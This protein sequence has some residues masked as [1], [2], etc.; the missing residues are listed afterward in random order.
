MPRKLLETIAKGMILIGDGAMGTQLQLV[1]LEPGGCGEGWNVD[2]PERV[3]GIQQ[4]YVDAGSQCLI[5]N[6]FG[7]SRITLRRHKQDGRAYEINRAASR[8]ARD[9]LGPDGF[10]LG[11]IGPFGGFLE[12]LGEYSRNE[13]VDV[14]TEQA[15]GLLDGGADAIIVETMTAL[16]EIEAAVVAARSVHS[17]CTLIGSLAYDRTV[18]DTYR[19]MMGIG[20][21]ES[22]AKL[23]EMGIDV[24]ACN[25]GTGID[26]TDYVRIVTEYRNCSDL[27]IM[28]QPNAGQPALMKGEVV[29]KETPEKMASHV[30][31]VIA[32]GASIVG[33]CCG[34]TPEHIKLFTQARDAVV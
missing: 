30:Q 5:T 28:A 7:G 14:F 26:I 22:V 31:E 17:D 4:C 15:Q 32:A 25:C 33:G 27:P 16:E 9:C 18:H 6:S 23:V 21:E 19:T 11:D 34:T 12:P 29:Y 1:G 3:A 24:L 13:V 8:I 10:V 20:P 2:H